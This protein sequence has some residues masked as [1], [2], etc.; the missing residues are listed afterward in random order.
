V[1][2]KKTFLGVK[3]YS[4]TLL[5]QDQKSPRIKPCMCSVSLRT[6]PSEK[7]CGMGTKILSSL[8]SFFPPP[9]Y[10][11]KREK[12]FWG[13]KQGQ[14]MPT[15]GKEVYYGLAGNQWEEV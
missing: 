4:P 15:G 2:I 1:S 12:D 6:N 3:E 10:P 14:N 5:H 9:C 8:Y 7:Y 11:E 13:E